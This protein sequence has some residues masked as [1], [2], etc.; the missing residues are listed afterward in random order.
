MAR[1][2]ESRGARR[3]RDRDDLAALAGDDESPVPALDGQG[4]DIGAGGFG[5]PQPVEG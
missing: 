3:E 1:S 5:H 2:I 4:L